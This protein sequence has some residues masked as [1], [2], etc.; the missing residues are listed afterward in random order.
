MAS[1]KRL[2]GVALVAGFALFAQELVKNGGFDPRPNPMDGWEC[3]Q[4][5]EATW[6]PIDYDGTTNATALCIHAEKQ[7][8][9]G[10][11]RQI[12]KCRPNTQYTLRAD[13][14]TEDC[15]LMITAA[16][17][18]GKV[19]ATI[20]GGRTVWAP[21][22]TSFVSGADGEVHILL[23]AECKG[24]KAYAAVDNVSLKEA[25]V[26][27]AAAEAA[28][29][30]KR[31]NIALGKPYTFSSKPNYNL[32]SDDGDVAQVTDGIYTKGYFWTQKST[33]GW[34]QGNGF[35]HITIDLGKVC[36]IQGFSVNTA[37]ALKATVPPP[38]N[39]NV[40]V[41]DDG[42]GWHAVGD[43]VANFQMKNGKPDLSKYS[44]L[45]LTDDIECKGRYVMFQFIFTNFFFVDEIEI[46]EGDESLLAKQMVGKTIKDPSIYRYDQQI[47]SV[48]KGEA[49][50][51]SEKLKKANSK[52]CKSI[53]EKL[54]NFT[55]NINTIEFEDSRKM[56]TVY[57]INQQH[58]SLFALNAEYLRAI[59]MTKPLFWENCRWDNLDPMETPAL[60]AKPIIVEMMRGEVRSASVN[61][62]N[63]TD[64]PLDFKVAVEGLPDGCGIELHETLYTLTL[65]GT[66]IA[67]A[68]K[69]GKG[70]AI[71]IKAIPGMNS[72]IWL[73]F[74]RPKLKAGTH[75]GKL[76]ATAGDFKLTL[77]L[78][79]LI[80]DFDF[81]KP[82]LH[83]GGWDYLHVK[84]GTRNMFGLQANP[85]KGRDAMRDIYV[86]SPWGANVQW[87]GSM[88]GPQ[89]AI[90]DADGHLTNSDK[91]DYSNWE[92]WLDF[93]SGARLYCVY[94]CVQK[95][96]NG[97]AMGTPRFNT[98]VKEYFGA[99]ADY[100]RKRNFPTEKVV[101]LII[102]EPWDN[103]KDRT[104]ITWAKPIIA[105]KTGF[106]LFEDPVHADHSKAL[107]EI[108]GLSD[109]LCP[110]RVLIIGN[111][112]PKAYR[113]FFMKFREQGK[114]LWLYS[115]SGPSRLLDPIS[116]YRA[117]AWE[118]FSMGAEGSFFWALGCGGG[119]NDS[120]RPFMQ[121]QNEYSPYFVSP[122][123]D[124]MPAKQSEAIRE[125]VQD[126]EYLCMLRDRIAEL[127]KSAKG[128][129]KLAAAEALLNEAPARA[130]RLV[131]TV[132]AN[133]VKNAKG[134]IMWDDE[135]DRTLM[136]TERVKVLRMLNA[137][138]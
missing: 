12:V 96:F 46:Y 70:A 17:K 25:T 44:V 136:D 10:V 133:A 80:Y 67:G 19:L 32:C 131:S 9:C 27:Q 125:S 62:M 79:L 64:R 84:K 93:W 128:G 74:N 103:E 24:G 75:K 40:F 94:L 82:R 101:L 92:Y 61:L 68:L 114:K 73:S 15:E 16:A 22:A 98:M 109:I 33:V 99:W 34:K 135:K 14:K 100:L 43:L 120:W 132:D 97:E 85:E 122:N 129:R 88:V 45:C 90:F 104:F 50:S 53:T 7:A 105:A 8:K 89:G 38:S 29:T 108:Y 123:N 60:N 65:Q 81:P 2:F 37:Y 86:D 119:I 111:A 47:L 28:Q 35:Q 107:P 72:Q 66:R 91:L 113:D 57:P 77:P 3:V 55:A 137:L 11:M 36:P 126:Y 56:L 31:K 42:K 41:S 134:A 127:H 13:I 20:K 63:P 30:A 69:P 106:Q 138:K 49:Y 121:T 59:G 1:Y 21:T 112:D 116:Y 110:N 6:E 95:N 71:D 39:I 102:D 117:Q 51:L 76:V 58:A 83:V 54:Q 87:G 48:F 23:A 115:C 124:T 118:A 5:G 4:K 18:D 52:D 26:P 130:L 78:E